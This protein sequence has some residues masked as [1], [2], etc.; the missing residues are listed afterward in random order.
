MIIVKFQ[1]GITTKLYRQELR[2][3]C[4]AYCLRMLYVSMKFHDNIL[5]GFQVIEWTRNNNS[6][7]LKGNNSKDVQTR[8][9]V[10]VVCICLMMLYISMKFHE[11]IL[12]DFQVIGRI[13]LRD[14]QT[15]RWTD[16]RGKNNVSIPVRGRHNYVLYIF[17][18]LNYN[19]YQLFPIFE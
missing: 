2:F 10:L 16:N 18:F 13:Q 1:R 17:F 3:L 14:G 8:V 6:L 12:N 9:M 19:T 5:N 11:N 7:I 4:S 15:D